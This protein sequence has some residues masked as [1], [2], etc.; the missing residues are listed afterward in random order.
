MRQTESVTL[1]YS[2]YSKCLHVLYSIFLHVDAL[3][4]NIYAYSGIFRTL[5]NIRIFT[6]LPFSQALPYLELEAYSKPCEALPRGIQNPPIVR[7]VY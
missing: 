4:R 7:T 5:C 6:T 1:A 2:M 3:L